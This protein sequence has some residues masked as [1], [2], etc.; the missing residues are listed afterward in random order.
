MNNTGFCS[1]GPGL[2]FQIGVSGPA[3]QRL[4]AL[5]SRGAWVNGTPEQAVTL[6]A[7]RML[8]FAIVLKMPFT[9]ADLDAL[10]LLHQLL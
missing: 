2:L 8:E 3:L 7:R 6:W 5:L 4:S 1:G 9:M 10:E